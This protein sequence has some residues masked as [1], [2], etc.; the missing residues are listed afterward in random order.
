MSEQRAV[1]H[2]THNSWIPAECSKSSK[3]LRTRVFGAFAGEES[4]RT[5]VTTE[6]VAADGEAN[7]D[8]KVRGIFSPRSK[9]HSGRLPYIQGE[10]TSIRSDSNAPRRKVICP[11]PC[12]EQSRVIKWCKWWNRECV[13]DYR[14]SSVAHLERSQCWQ[15]L[16]ESR[17]G[18]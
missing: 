16:C 5:G 11:G 13:F 9:T 6:R 1:E 8:K 2:G 7:A 14:Q 4:D 12:A 10:L 18:L 3:V 15:C 17:A